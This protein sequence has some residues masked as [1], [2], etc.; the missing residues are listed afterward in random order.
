MGIPAGALRGCRHLRQT[1]GFSVSGRKT[2]EFCENSGYRSDRFSGQSTWRARL[3]ARGEDVRVLVRPSSDL[4]ALEGLA[5]ERVQGDLRDRVSLDRA[6]EGVQRV[7]HVAA[8]YRLWAR[9]PAGD[10]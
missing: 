10:S 5:A 3:L 2:G 1:L 6:M 9:R 4:R 8:D 7:Y